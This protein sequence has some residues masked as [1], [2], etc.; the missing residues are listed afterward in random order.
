MKLP[1]G[2][3]VEDQ[4][5]IKLGF[6]MQTSSSRMNEDPFDIITPIIINVGALKPDNP[7]K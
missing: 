3:K 7:A 5:E 2:Y 4:T 1:E 6:Q